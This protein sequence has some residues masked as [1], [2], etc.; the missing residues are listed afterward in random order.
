M[1]KI[2]IIIFIIGVVLVSG[3]IGSLISLS[4]SKDAIGDNIGIYSVSTPT[5]PVDETGLVRDFFSKWTDLIKDFFNQFLR[6]I[7][8]ES[9]LTEIYTPTMNS[10]NLSPA[11]P[12][13]PAS[14][15][16]STPPAP[17]TP[18]VLINSHEQA[19]IKTV[20][21]VAPSVVSIIVSKD[22]P[23][24]EKFPHNPSFNL[25]FEF[26]EFFDQHFEIY[27]YREIGVERRK[28]GGG[29][30]FIISKDGLIVTNK[31]VVND[32]DAFYT[33]F[34]S[35]GKK[36][37][38]EVIAI[39]PILDLAIIKIESN[40]L[41]VVKLGDSDL[42]KLGQTAIVIGNA[43]GEFQ[44]TVSVGVISG[45]SRTIIASGRGII[46]R[47]EN[48]IQTDAAINQGNS[49]GPLLNLRGEVIGINVAMVYGAQNIGFAIPINQA[50]KS[51]DSV[52]QTG[53]I[54]IPYLGV[55]YLNISPE[56][57]KKENLLIE[58]GALIRGSE[59]R[60]A[61]LPN[62]P[63]SRAGLQAEDIIIE[64]NKEKITQKR[65][66]G[67]LIRKYSA[68]ETIVIKILRNNKILELKAT[69]EERNF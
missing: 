23:V 25:P 37:E 27:Q 59:N 22:T 13:S 48:V 24:I 62:S 38:A 65:S 40:N 2:K 49:G 28:I 50:K 26:Q 63:A 36:Y 43:L 56:L 6:L 21:N 69:L 12:V 31:H 4:Y 66:L 3:I 35:D 8:S 47:I 32:P 29:S 10:T 60:P 51:I 52:K 44:N 46:Q 39:D 30:G 61:I 58:N 19:I 5:F 14:P 7:Q 16:L 45:L 15:M 18:C 55:R 33:V 64:I 57:V 41:P 67:S 11:S 17:I 1:K 53:R 9:S 68:G 42:I 20:E 34:T 54:I